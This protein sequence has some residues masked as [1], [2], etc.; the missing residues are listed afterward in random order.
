MVMSCY[1]DPSCVMTAADQPSL[2]F[3]AMADGSVCTP[4]HRSPHCTAA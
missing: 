2:V 1:G 3:A 4:Q